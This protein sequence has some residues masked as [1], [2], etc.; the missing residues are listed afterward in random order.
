M[1]VATAGHVDHGKTTLVRA[2]TGIDTD[3]LPEEKRRGISIDLG[4]A[5]VTTPEHG[6]IGFV[7][8][9][10]HERFVHN[11]IAG[12]A[13]VDL[14]MLVVA[15]D[16]GVM[17]QTR[18]HVS[19]LEMVG[20]PHVIVAVTKVDAVS[21]SRVAEVILEV[22]RLLAGRALEA[23][24][25]VAVS[26]PHG[27]GIDRLRDALCRYH[28]GL[29][30]RHQ[31]GDSAFRFIIDR[32]F[33]AA[34]S[35]TVVTG[36]VVA[37]SVAAG[38]VLVASPSGASVRVRGIQ[39]DRQAVACAEA[40]ERYAINLAGVDRS[41]VERGQV[42]LSPHLHRTTDRLDV[43]VRS[44]P[45]GDETLRH[46]TPVHFHSGA[47]RVPARVILPRSAGIGRG[48]RA[49]AQLRLERPVAAFTGDRFV[50]RDASA[51]R[52][53][54]G[55]RVID[56]LGEPRRRG[57]DP[58]PRLQALAT[59]SA[60]AAFARLMEVT[61]AGVNVAAFGQ[62][63]ALSQ[64]GL[65][66]LSNGPDVVLLR[67]ESVLAFR[68]EAIASLGERI[69]AVLGAF[70]TEHP[71]E[72]GPSQQLLHRECAPTLPSNVFVALLKWLSD[73]GI[74][75]LRRDHAT[76]QGFRPSE[77]DGATRLLRIIEPALASAGL[78]GLEGSALLGLSGD[79]ERAHR[80][81]SHLVERGDLCAFK[82]DRYLS[83]A[84]VDRLVGMAR[85]LARE[86]PDG[87]SAAQF[88]DHAGVGRNLT[89]DIL[90]FL[91]RRAV[92]FRVADVRFVRDDEG[93]I[94]G[95]ACATGSA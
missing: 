56:P 87:F 47:A 69:V 79:P 76:L 9:P 30:R 45:E 84:A 1:I 17:P 57:I 92:T 2:L 25:V 70:H 21:E 13:A 28:A 88:R 74:L 16:D 40:G 86:H 52:T 12:V 63:F 80:D 49:F 58:M 46:W 32:T 5:Y 68:K 94:R 55:G 91:D 78:R 15:A 50:L 42:L 34:G 83:R 73:R 38:D 20:V 3:R 6:K 53:I 54:A 27:H 7:D 62:R 81:L 36:T 39:H 43:E 61:P 24:A 11:M 89:I 33:V 22:E 44:T 31:G 26:A 37:G 10:G 67:V 41:Q 23:C 14:G 4:F 60:E 64:R 35:G 51:Q 95:N 72:G 77:R 66:R 93:A 59:G 29:Q 90:E 65:Q 18:E 82:G 8:V 71:Q 48:E 85:H 75:D 19:I